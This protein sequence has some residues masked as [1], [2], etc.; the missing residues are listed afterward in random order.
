MNKQK[1]NMRVVCV[2]LAVLAVSH[3]AYFQLELGQEQY[4]LCVCMC[5]RS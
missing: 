1:K 2:L 4:V 5:Q 3:A